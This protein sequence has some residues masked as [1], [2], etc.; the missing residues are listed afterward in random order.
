MKLRRQ[1]TQVE[2]W[3][4]KKKSVGLQTGPHTQRAGR[5]HREKEATPDWGVAALMSKGIDLHDFSWEAAGRRSP[6]PPARIF[7]V[8]TEALTGF[9]NVNQRADLS[10]LLSQGYVLETHQLWNGGR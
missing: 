2:K 4:K 10:T 6:H 3:A 8:H 7:K 9:S 1:T 5:D